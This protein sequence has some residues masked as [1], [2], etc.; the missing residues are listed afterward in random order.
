MRLS[1]VCPGS[2]NSVCVQSA[3][4]PETPATTAAAATATTAVE[5]TPVPAAVQPCCLSEMGGNGRAVFWCCPVVIVVEEVD[6][7]RAIS[8]PSYNRSKSK[9]QG[10][11]CLV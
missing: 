9:M 5:E 7:G 4:A 11:I 6:E 3:G 2:A 8:I 10:A 1:F